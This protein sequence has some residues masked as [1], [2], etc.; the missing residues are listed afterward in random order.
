MKKIVLKKIR[1]KL[2]S[3]FQQRSKNLTWASPFI[4]AERGGKHAFIKKDLF[5]FYLAVSRNITPDVS[6]TPKKIWLW[7]QKD[8]DLLA[9][10]RIQHTPRINEQISMPFFYRKTPDSPLKT[11]QVHL[12]TDEASYLDNT[13][14][15]WSKSAHV[16]SLDFLARHRVYLRVINYAIMR[17]IASK[18]TDRWN[19]GADSHRTLN[20]SHKK[21]F[22]RLKEGLDIHL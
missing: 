6:K 19:P 7:I 22:K 12:F 21:L 8:R 2:Q 5:T 9:L 15:D 18:T 3:T 13:R 17:P 4:K 1:S 16:T 14:S 11:V 20:Y 10:T